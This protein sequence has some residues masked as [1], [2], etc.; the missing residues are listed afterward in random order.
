M[1]FKDEYVKYA[2]DFMAKLHPEWNKDELVKAV[3]H[4]YKS[5]LKDPTIVMDNNVTGAG[6]TITFT[7]LCGWIKQ[8]NPV[9]SGN[10]TFYCQPSSLRSPTSKMLKTLKMERKAVKNKMFTMDP[11]SDEY[12]SA[13]L[14]QGNKKVIMNAD[15]GGS[16]APTAAFYTLYSPP[17]TTLMAQSII[18][19]MAAF[20]ESYLGDN[21]VF[22]SLPECCDWMMAVIKKDEKIPGWI[23]VPTK[24]ETTKRILSKFISLSPAYI[25][26][27]EKFVNNCTDTELIY[28]FYANN[29]KDLIRRH[30]HI[31]NLVRD[32]LV[33]LPNIEAAEEVPEAYKDKF[34][35]AKDYNEWVSG[36]MFL[37]PYKPPKAIKETLDKFIGYM[38]QFVYVEY[39]TPDSIVKLNNHKRNTVLLVDTDSNIINAN[40][41]VS[42][43]L[44]EIF[45]G[46][47]F[48]RTKLYN[49]MILVN[50]IC[51][52]LS[53]SVADILDYYGE[54]HN[55][56]PEARKELT[57]KNEFM[58]RVLFLLDRKKRYCASIVL[59]EGNMMIPYKPE[60]KG[61]DFIKAGVTENVSKLFEKMLCNRIIFSD[62][63]ELHELMSDLKKFERSI[64]DN[65]R[66]G[67]KEYLKSSA[68]KPESGYKS[69][70]GAWKLQTF[71]GAMIWNELYPNNKIYSLDR[72]HILK[73]AVEDSSDL[74]KIKDT[75]PE[76]YKLAM[77]NIYKNE[78]PSIV[79]TG[80]SV[81]CIPTSVKKI[82]EWLIPLID[83]DQI[84]SNTVSSFKS[85]LRSLNI[86]E[87]PFKT[88]AG[89]ASLT[90]CL[91]NL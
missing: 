74:N 83:Y 13:D 90:T 82:P 17:A 15:Y 66:N 65:L 76:E 4:I 86:E 87:I 20:F 69:K 18:T 59:R 79:K 9:I 63:L 35:S 38:K 3:E 21:Q 37:N 48:G 81:I 75:F 51:A 53:V 64:Y 73:L 56:D 50:V 39:L 44:N 8:T 33:T 41:F 42:F 34:A 40:L 12:A 25:P 19:T 52:S 5:N 60:I 29:F 14:D 45:P 57:M 10:A 71:K 11:K 47:M 31:Q 6:A 72:V 26:I 49:E 27:V 32:I 68:F 7:K 85:I 1:S 46:E 78:N 58:F 22:F 55:M 2:S 62:K 23:K 67:G 70:E 80:L 77:E 36:E 28:L 43:I 61:V 89:N 24:P 91:I 54:T 30:K 88:S 16:G 84:I